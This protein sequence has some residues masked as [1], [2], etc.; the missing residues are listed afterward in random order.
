MKPFAN[1]LIATVVAAFCVTAPASAVELSDEDVDNL[2]RRTYPYVAMYNVINKAAMMEENPQRTGWN[3]TF[4]NTNLTDHTANTIARPNNDTLYVPTLMD[5]RND[6]VVV[7]YP[8]FDSKFVNLQISAYDH[9]CD[10]PLSTTKGDFKKPTKLL[11]YSKRTKDYDGKPVEGVDRVIE[12]SGDFVVAFLRVMPHAAEPERFERIVAAMKEVKA[13]TLAEYLGQPPKPTDEPEFPAYQAS[14]ADIFEKNF[15]E[16]MQFVVD[17]TTFDPADELD[18]AVLVAL[19]P[20]GIKPGATPDPAAAG[21]IDGKA[22][23]ET[24]RRIHQEAIEIWNSPEGNPHV[25]ALFMPKGQIALEPMVVQSAYGPIGLPAHQAVYPGII[26]T[27]GKP[28]NAGND[29]VI[30]MSK[31]QM[32]PAEA[33][34]SVTLYDSKNGFF[35]PNERKKYSVGEN[36]GLKLD[37]NG[38][39]EIHVAAEQ[40]EGIPEENWLPIVRGDEA[41]DIVMRLYAPDVEKMKLWQAPKAEKISK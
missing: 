24:A 39:I 5:L 31:D 11:F 4:A 19:E 38:G 25:N 28:L 29:Y 26:A 40:P 33:F 20:L 2:V 21:K 17:H 10:V 13:V 16:V 32:P 35:I 23:A 1:M 9:Y 41:L 12:M 15:A 36:A 7:S 14:D 6:A 22:M 3:G 27:D 30:R 34:W 18:T 37:E 8:A